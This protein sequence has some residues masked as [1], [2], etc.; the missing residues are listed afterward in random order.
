MMGVMASKAGDRRDIIAQVDVG[1]RNRM[2]HHGMIK[3]VSFVE[4]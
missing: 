2:P 3:L 4:V 1:P